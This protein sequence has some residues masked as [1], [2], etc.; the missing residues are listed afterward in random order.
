MSA[1]R[2]PAIL[3]EAAAQQRANR[4]AGTSAGSASQSGSPRSTAAS[5]SRHVLAVERTLARQHLVEHAAE[6]P[7]VARLSDRLAPAPAPA[8]MYAA[9]PRITP[10]PVIIAGVV[11]VGDCGDVGGAGRAAGSVRL[12]QAEVEDL[13]GA[14]GPHLDVR[15]LQ[16]AVDDPLLVRRFERLG[17][18]LRDR[19]RLV[20]R[21]RPARDPLR[22]G[23]RPRPVPSRGP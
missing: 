15:G 2:S 21:D 3:L 4:Q 19:Q 13:H 18:L 10:T 8:T 12:R 20:E 23:P 9:V 7:D 17:D 5:V 6:R 14:V 1:I 22:R 16:I 11:I